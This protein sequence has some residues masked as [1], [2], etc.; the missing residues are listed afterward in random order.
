MEYLSPKLMAIKTQKID[1][2][3]NTSKQ[4]IDRII[5][6]ATDVGYTSVVHSGLCYFDNIYYHIEDDGDDDN[7]ICSSV[8]DCSGYVFPYNLL[9]HHTKNEWKFKALMMYM[10][11]YRNLLPINSI[12]GKVDFPKQVNIK[13]TDGRIHASIIRN[14][15]G[16]KL[17]DDG[18]IY[19]T[20]EFHE[21]GEPIESDIRN[22]DTFSKSMELNEFL[23]INPDIKGIN[24]T[25][26]NFTENERNTEDTVKNN[27][28]EEFNKLQ[29]HWINVAVNP[30]L[31]NY[32]MINITTMTE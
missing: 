20:L 5:A 18:N 30:V 8:V 12:F 28:M 25:L 1:E 3:P 9:Q 31:T 27:V 21:Y 7:G 19:V 11:I 32:K 10:F 2:I 22:Y 4:I 13:R 23:E 15:S 29:Q 14:D 16:L 6:L 24:A 17:K 26:T